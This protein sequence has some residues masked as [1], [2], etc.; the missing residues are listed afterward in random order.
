MYSVKEKSFG[1]PILRPL[2]NV[3][4]LGSLFCVMIKTFK[5]LDN[6]INTI[7]LLNLTAPLNKFYN[8]FMLIC[9]F[10]LVLRLCYLKRKKLRYLMCG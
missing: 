3:A 8:H 6:V 5:H 2:P 9:S 7:V 10:I 1:L 4:L